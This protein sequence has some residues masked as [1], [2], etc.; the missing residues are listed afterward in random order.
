MP[1][2]ATADASDP[3]AEY[4]LDREEA[5][6]GARQLADDGVDAIMINGRSVKRRRSPKRSGRTSLESSSRLSTGTCRLS[7]VRP[8]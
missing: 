2:P 7:P 3:A 8:R 6:R 1:T 4:T 5:E